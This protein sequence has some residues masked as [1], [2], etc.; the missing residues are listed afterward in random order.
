MI[1]GPAAIAESAAKVPMGRL[2]TPEDIAE[3]VCFLMGDG[4]R[5]MNGSVV[6]VT[7]GMKP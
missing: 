1:A 3:V 4:A 5:Y 6:E 2:G 7:G